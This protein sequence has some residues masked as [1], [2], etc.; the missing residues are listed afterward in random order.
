MLVS[1]LLSL[2]Y[3]DITSRIRERRTFPPLSPS[4]FLSP[5]IISRLHLH[6]NDM[7]NALAMR[8]PG[9]FRILS[10][11]PRLRPTSPFSFPRISSSSFHFSL[12]KR[13]KG[14]SKGT[15]GQLIYAVCL[16][17]GGTFRQAGRRRD[18]INSQAFFFFSNCERW[19][20]VREAKGEGEE[21]GKGGGRIPII[22]RSDGVQTK[23]FAFLLSLSFFFFFFLLF[24]G[25]RELELGRD[26]SFVACL[27]RDLYIYY[28]TDN[29]RSGWI[30][31][32]YKFKRFLRS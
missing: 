6:F 3:R 5:V 10:A 27:R 22:K 30:I 7:R 29:S 20:G 28:T 18:Q 16:E 17:G 1:F 26:W 11:L 12:Q 23:A 8:H 9:S 25:T 19:K 13:N 15:I 2:Y 4:L 14:N 21:G 24:R 32:F 31:V